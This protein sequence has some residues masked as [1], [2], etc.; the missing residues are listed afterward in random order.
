M[1]WMVYTP[2]NGRSNATHCQN[3]EPCTDEQGLSSPGTFNPLAPV[4]LFCLWEGFTA[5]TYQD[6]E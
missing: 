5:M 3:L 2:A 4:S 6:G 1:L